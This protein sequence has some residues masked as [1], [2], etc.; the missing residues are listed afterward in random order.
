MFAAAGVTGVTVDNYEA[1]KT[2]VE[3]AEK[4]GTAG[5]GVTP[6]HE[7]T[8]ADLQEIVDGINNPA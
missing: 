6:I 5:D 1:V 2:A 3:N 4:T 7:L 8:K